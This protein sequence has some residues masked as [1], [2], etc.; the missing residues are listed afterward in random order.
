MDE[1]GSSKLTVKKSTQVIEK[2]GKLI[3]T[4]KHD[5][6]TPM[7]IIS[8]IPPAFATARMRN[9]INEINQGIRE[10]ARKFDIPFVSADIPTQMKPCFQKN[11]KHLSDFGLRTLL[12]HQ[13]KKVEEFLVDKRAKTVSERPELK[14]TEENKWGLASRGS[15]FQKTHQIPM[16]MIGNDEPRKKIGRITFIGDSVYRNLVSPRV[17][18]MP[19]DFPLDHAIISFPGV[20]LNKVNRRIIMK[21]LKEQDYINTDIIFICIGTNHLRNI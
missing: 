19:D 17:A 12:A 9:E 20:T 10:K 8:G 18:T 13:R 21:V 4:I 1:A 7:I 14:K 5:L 2:V 11:R 16:G 3:R 6:P 15:Y